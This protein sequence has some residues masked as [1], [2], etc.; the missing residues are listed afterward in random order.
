MTRERGNPLLK[1][2]DRRVGIP[3]VFLAGLWRALWYRSRRNAPAS[4]QFPPARIGILAMGAIGDTIIIGGII[5]DLARAFPTSTLV[6][7]TSDAN[8]AVAPLLAHVGEHLALPI[9]RPWRAVAPLR[10]THLDILI[11]TGPW[12]RISALLSA[13]SGAG[14]IVGFRTP[15]QHRH[16]PYDI[17]VDHR[18]DCHQI[19]NFRA[20]IRPL[21]VEANALP[22]LQFSGSPAVVSTLP[23]RYVVFHPW[24]GGF[25]SH[26]K[27]W[28]ESEWLELG[29]RI[30][31][32]QLHMVLTGAPADVSA[33]AALARK[34]KSGGVD[35]IDL[36]GRCSLGETARILAKAVFVVSVD[37]GIAHIAAATG[38]PTVGLYGPASSKR[39]GAMGPKVIAIDS[40]S[41]EGGY[42]DLGY[43]YPAQPPPVME[44]LSVN[45]VWKHVVESCLLSEDEGFK[46]GSD[47]HHNIATA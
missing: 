32:H 2:I 35:V 31:L 30:D 36:A 17:V 26:F 11:D 8:R 9:T 43:E 33:S 4:P 44:S 38:T 5:A 28:P 42:L 46:S 39:W 23:S 19:E 27:Q 40:P 47:H 13:I 29:R 21:G 37:T 16:Y 25:R 24:P 6:L 45:Y 1:A 20:L 22:A 34:M 7:I 12:P 3:L 15:R 18:S 14:K 41:P 10:A